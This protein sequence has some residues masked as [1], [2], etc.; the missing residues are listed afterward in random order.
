MPGA[1]QNRSELGIGLWWGKFPVLSAM[2]FRYRYK[3]FSIGDIEIRI[4]MPRDLKQFTG[5][6]GQ[7]KEG[8]ISEEALPLFGIVWHSAEIL[9]RLMLDHDI[10]GKRILEVGC[11]MA[12]VSHLLNSLGADIT[13][14]DIHPVTAELINGNAALNHARPIPFL[15]ASWSDDLPDLGKFDLIVGSDILYE[16]KHAK[17]LAPFINLHAKSRSEVIIVD[18]D[19]GQ[20][21]DF[22]KQMSGYGF[23]CESFSPDFP[24]R[25]GIPYRGVA[26]RY[27][28]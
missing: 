6:D 11:G 9:C 16:P 7:V 21:E 5:P 3:T 1:C 4:R 23:S 10:A 2:S 12:L 8:S 14:M 26:D 25:P 15:N 22:R 19:R 24:D 20:L 18:P 17:T 28:R 27:C 13:A